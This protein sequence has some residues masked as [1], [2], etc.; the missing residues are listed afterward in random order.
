MKLFEGSEP[1]HYLTPMDAGL[2]VTFNGDVYVA[3]RATS[4]GWFWK[5]KSGRFPEENPEEF[6]NWH[7]EIYQKPRFFPLRKTPKP[8]PTMGT[9]SKVVEVPIELQEPSKAY[10]YAK[11]TLGGQPWADGEFFIGKSPRYAYLYAKNILKDRFWKAEKIV[12]SNIQWA[13]PYSIDVMKKRWPEIESR[14]S[15]FPYFLNA[16]CSAFKLTYNQQTNSFR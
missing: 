2:E 8:K 14:I 7:S 13:V 10:E 16:Y 11:Y 12:E 6:F 3:T 5:K 9:K 4:S 1:L 15:E